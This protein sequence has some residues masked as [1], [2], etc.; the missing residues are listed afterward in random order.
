ML[1][2]AV[3]IFCKLIFNICNLHYNSTDLKRYQNMGVQKYCLQKNF[4]YWY[5]QRNQ[6]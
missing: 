2:Y 1:Q 5:I 6:R 3:Y 4:C